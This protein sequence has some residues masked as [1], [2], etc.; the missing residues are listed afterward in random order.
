MN[1]ILQLGHQMLHPCTS[2]CRLKSRTPGPRGLTGGCRWSVCQDDLP[3]VGSL[4]DTQLRTSLC[5][6]LLPGEQRVPACAVWQQVTWNTCQGTEMKSPSLISWKLLLNVTFWV[7]KSSKVHNPLCWLTAH[8]KLESGHLLAIRISL[9]LAS[10][11][12]VDVPEP[13]GTWKTLCLVSL[14]RMNL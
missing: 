1:V 4:S 3:A 13:P 12:L 10:L 2:Q 6:G 11:W 9:F 8:S 14:L 5:S 7:R